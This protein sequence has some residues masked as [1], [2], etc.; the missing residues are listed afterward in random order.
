MVILDLPMT[1]TTIIAILVAVLLLGLALSAFSLWASARLARV[2][3]LKVGKAFTLAGFVVVLPLFVLVSLALGGVIE[4]NS[5]V[6]WGVGLASLLGLTIYLRRSL[7][8]AWSRTLL[9]LALFLIINGLCCVCL[10]FR[11]GAG[12]LASY[13]M[14]TGSCAPA[15][16]GLHVDAVCP[17]C[18]VQ[19]PVGARNPPQPLTFPC[20]NCRAAIQVPADASLIGGDRFLIQKLIAPRRWDLVAYVE[21][22]GKLFMHRLVGLAGETLDIVDGDLFADGKRLARRPS[23]ADEMWVPV[24]DSGPCKSDRQPLGWKP[25]GRVDPHPPIGGWLLAG[26]GSGL[27]L[28]SPID[29]S[30]PYNSAAP[31]RLEQ[32][33]VLVHDARVEIA[34]AY[35]I[36]IDEKAPWLV[37]QWKHCERSAQASFGPS[38]A[39][40]IEGG[41]GRTTGGLGGSLR[42][43]KIVFQVRDGV[44]AVL[45][46]GKEIAS[47]EIGPQDLLETGRLPFGVPC[48]LS[49]RVR[50]G[51]VGID[52]ILLSRDIYY[53]KDLGTAAW[54]VLLGPDQFFVLGDNC[55][56]SF[57]SRYLGVVSAEK[58]AGVACWLFAP[59][60]RSRFFE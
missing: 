51:A 24:H 4:W 38:G 39:V 36:E 31:A 37:L 13:Q 12:A 20:P 55:H 30:L 29:D 7:G 14:T 32:R 16:I 41:G 50:E 17:S 18:G 52:R 34:I 9:I 46:A 22:E 3:S 33:K 26:P 53:R 42:G 19:F 25:F 8:A 2:H 49:I 28:E 15:I 58:I 45:C 44:A 10:A 60:S 27:E 5:S 1:L 56:M 43:K 47:L 11:F 57:D 40:E 48:E 21:P 23:E 59:W 35:T 54:P 6:T